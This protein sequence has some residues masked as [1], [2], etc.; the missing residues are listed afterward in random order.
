M[1]PYKER[2]SHELKSNGLRVTKARLYV[3]EL[4]HATSK[5]LSHQDIEERL[6]SKGIDLDTVTIYRTLSSL[7]K[8]DIIHKITGSD[9]SFHYAYVNSSKHTGHINTSSHP[10]F[11]CQ[12][13]THTY[14]LPEL[15]SPITIETP[16]G[17]QYT[18]AEITLVGFCPQ[19]A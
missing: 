11:T 9:R 15:V 10:H 18:H 5:A 2:L 14:C 7:T 8:A 19:C 6:Q 13:C 12:K 3:L 4:F 16:K 17:F 1:M